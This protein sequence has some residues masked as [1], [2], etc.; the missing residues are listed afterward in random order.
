MK[1]VYRLSGDCLHVGIRLPLALKLQ[2]HVKRLNCLY[3]G[4]HVKIASFKAM[5]LLK[6]Q[7]IY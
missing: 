6:T 2:P 1:L 5:D 4:L 3:R 7:A